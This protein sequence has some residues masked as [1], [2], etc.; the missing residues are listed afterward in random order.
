M[1]VRFCNCLRE[2]GCLGC[3]QSSCM[4]EN[5][6]TGLICITDAISMMKWFIGRKEKLGSY[7]FLPSV[8]AKP[9]QLFRNCKRMKKRRLTGHTSEGDLLII[10][11]SI[12]KTSALSLLRTSAKSRPYSVLMIR[13]K[14]SLPKK[15]VKQSCFEI[16]WKGR[17][18]GPFSLALSQKA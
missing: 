16:Y 11:Q 2:L 18:C 5:S 3:V 4:L 10:S 13:S 12:D 8:S 15:L 17:N 1:I 9:V 14:R 6:E 7:S